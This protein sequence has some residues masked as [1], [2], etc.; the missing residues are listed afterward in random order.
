MKVIKRAVDYHPRDF[1]HG[2]D[3]IESTLCIL[4]FGTVSFP[5]I[6]TVT[7]SIL[8]DRKFINTVSLLSFVKL[9]KIW[10]TID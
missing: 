6:E 10:I 5:L 7:L 2:E 8:K 9:S 1:P 4:L 3:S